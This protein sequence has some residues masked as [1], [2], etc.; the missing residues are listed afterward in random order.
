MAKKRSITQQPPRNPGE[1]QPRPVA[2]DRWTHF[3]NALARPVSGASLAIFRMAVG[4]V[5]ALEAFSL[6]RPS[7]STAGKVMLETYYT[8]P[9]I[10]FHFPYA[11]FEWLPWLPRSGMFAVVGL[12]ALG[13]L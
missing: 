11:W 7:A 13:S 2:P 6:L 3:K 5:M 8:G 9:D 10:K 12:L 1:G 4:L